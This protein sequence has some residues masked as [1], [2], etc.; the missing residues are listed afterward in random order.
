MR[1]LRWLRDLVADRGYAASVAG[2]LAGA[3]ILIALAFAAHAQQDPYEPGELQNRTIVYAGS[4]IE[5][6]LSVQATQF[7][8]S[9]AGGLTAT[10]NSST[11]GYNCDTTASCTALSVFATVPAGTGAN[12]SAD[13]EIG[14]F[15]TV[16]DEGSNALSLYPPVGSGYFINGMS[17]NAP[18]VIAA[19]QLATLQ[20]VGPTDYRTLGGSGSSP[21]A[22]IP[23]AGGV[24]CTNG[25]AGT[26]S[27]CGAQRNAANG[28]APTDANNL[29]PYASLP[30]AVQERIISLS[31]VGVPA[32]SQIAQAVLTFACPTGLNYAGSASWVNTAPASS[33]VIGL[34]S[35]HSGTPTT[36]G[37]VTVAGAAHTGS[38]PAHASVSLAAGDVLQAIAPAS[39]DATAADITL[40]V[41]CLTATP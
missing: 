19:G 35:I 12:I 11:T 4:S 14:A 39:P 31:F 10:G 21:A 24:L 20:R 18:L 36:E 38:W 9:V 40:A 5:Q 13:L 17:A 26:A 1:L 23:A 29:V 22:V 30:A 28:L 3:G 32:A 6:L 34:T 33:L 25:T 7:Q 16:V 27:A 41:A 2:A 37:V 8:S 15:V